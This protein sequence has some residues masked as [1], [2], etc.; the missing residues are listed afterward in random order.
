MSYAGN[1][2]KL[3]QSAQTIRDL[4]CEA[5]R[6]FELRT[7]GVSSGWG[8]TRMKT[9]D[10]GMDSIGKF[11][12]SAWLKIAAFC[13]D[14]KLIPALLIKA[15]FKDCKY[16]PEPNQA[17]GTHAL[18]VYTTYMAKSTQMAMQNDFMVAFESQKASVAAN[19]VR[20][21]TYSGNDD[22]IALLRAVLDKSASISQLFK[23]CILKNQN[24]PIAEDFFDVAKLLYE[25]DPDMYDATWGDWIPKELKE[26]VKRT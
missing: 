19:M 23:Y 21:K 2:K 25:Q 18:S 5:V 11:H 3:E 10:G 4:W 16:K 26:D 6:M 8:N 20:Y 1:E 22:R 14:N 17:Y 24:E 13:E 9:W 7:T 12:K 15:L